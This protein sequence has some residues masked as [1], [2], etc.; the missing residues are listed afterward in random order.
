MVLLRSWLSMDIQQRLVNESQSAAHWF[1]RPTT[2]GGGK[3][4]LWQVFWMHNTLVEVLFLESNQVVLVFS[5][6]M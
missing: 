3:Y 2:A 1:K 6:R 5:D 4:H